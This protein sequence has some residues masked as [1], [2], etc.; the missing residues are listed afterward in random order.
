MNTL[1]D[2]I[3][4]KQSEIENKQSEIENKQSEIDFFELEESNYESSYDDMLDECYPEVFNILPSRILSEC[5]P[6]AYR[7]GLSDYL[8]SIDVSD[9]T[10]YQKLEEELEE[11]ETEL[12]EL[13]T[14]LEEL[15]DELENIL[16]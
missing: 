16:S 7:C 6:I 5:D 8:D 9:D 15:E 10:N 1:E 11:L 12:E 2:Q 3:E 13:E 4:N 14:E